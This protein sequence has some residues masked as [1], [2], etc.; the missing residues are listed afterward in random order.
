MN[1]T[2]ITSG[3]IWTQIVL[4]ALLPVY[5]IAKTLQPSDNLSSQPAYTVSPF[6]VDRQNNSQSNE[7][8]YVLP[9]SAT[10]SQGARMLAAGNTIDSTRSLAVGA[11]S[12]ELQ[13]WLSQFGTARIE[14]NMDRH[15]SWGHSSGDLLVP[16]YD[17]R[18]SLLFVQGGMRKPSDRLTGNLGLG[19]RTFWQNGWMYGGN[20]FFDEDFTGHNRRVGIGGEAW[21]DYLRLSANTYVGTTSWHT[22]RDFDGSWQE[23]PADGYDVR[24]QGWLPA[25]PQ[26]GAK[27]VWEQYYGSQVALFD[28]DHLQRNPYAVTAGVEY[29]PVPLVTLGADQKQGS[30][31]HDTQLTLGLHWQFGH[32]WRWQLDPAN[33]QA[34]RTLAGSR[35]ELVDRNNEIVLQ[36]RKSPEQGVSHL[37]MTVVTDNSPADGVTRNVLQVLATNRDGQPVR[38]APLSWRV[39]SDG[40][41]TLSTASAVTDENGLASATLTSTKVQTVPVTAQS[42][43]VSASQNSHFM[44]VAVSRIA[45]TVTQDNAVADG[46]SAD[47]VTATLT[48][49]N[50]RPVARQSVTWTVPEGVTLREKSSVSDASGR[51]TVHL[52]ATVAGSAVIRAA[53]GNQGADGTV[54]FTGNAASAKVAT[55][56]VTTDGSPSDG[57]TANVAQV[58][59]TDAN[60]NAL[61]GQAVSWKADKSTVTFGQ[62]AATDSTGKTTVNYTD[63]VAESLTLTAT[64]ANGNGATASSLF[65]SDKN[66]ARLKSLD[67]TSGA[68][69]SGTDANTATVTVTD[70]NGNPLANTAVT[71][72]VTGSAKLNATTVNTDGS[73]RAQA[74]LTDVQAETVQV[75]AKLATG[76]SMTKESSFVADLNSAQLAVTATSGALADGSAVNTATVTLKDRN[77]TPQSGQTITLSTTGDAKL[78]AAS[79][80]TDASGQVVVVLTDTAAETVTLTASLSNGKQATAQAAFTGFSV[81]E[82]KTSA[83]SVKANGTDSATLTATVKDASG[84]VLA[85]T[86][87]VFS[88]TGSAE[89]SA[90]TATTNASGQV[91]VTLTD[92]AGEKVTVTAKAQ[93]SRSDAGKTTDVTFVASAV[94]GVTVNN[95]YATKGID[96]SRIFT[97]DSGFPKTGFAG[98]SFTLSIDNGTLP[99]TDYTWSSS[100]SWVSVSNGTVTFTGKPTSGTKNVTIT[101]TPKS[102]KG[103][104][105]W[106]FTLESWFT[107]IG[108]AKGIAETDS[109]CSSL[110]QSVPS[111]DLLDY[112]SFGGTQVGSLWSEWANSVPQQGVGAVWASETGR[113]SRYYMIMDT[114]QIYDNAGP[115]EDTG[116]GPSDYSFGAACML[117]L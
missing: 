104:V 4:Q 43:S 75:S 45:L 69:A 107:L 92:G 9:Y 50:G 67:V 72:S 94:T 105:T 89:L 85:S 100:Q 36:Y 14:L 2:N 55:L 116:E 90:T 19:V 78:S 42:G 30:G 65:V 96:N 58:T 29:T 79:G 32:N 60:G 34:M 31:E 76:S 102:G 39:P 70:A 62:S 44:A 61:A 13:Q 73:G 71:F 112:T 33:V 10:L 40:S 106:S 46:S 111:K 63:T 7:P 87:V 17:S 64:L 16:L 47:A 66:S 113:N 82:L 114:G 98:A 103:T 20:V 110:G 83:A 48:D 3:V 5:S 8:G 57:K 115:E 15:G 95:T 37:A 53:A 117:E 49:S 22:S 25:F 97:G 24:A 91:Q 6:Q 12:G 93:N 68:K 108:G 84:K 28:R 35:Y 81:T 77:G 101:A 80:T 21:R 99:V 56:S 52:T 109:T 23:K 11:A 1:K 59:V 27:L 86:P 54:H 41:A 26:L 18:E 51:V 88:V 74:T 38:N